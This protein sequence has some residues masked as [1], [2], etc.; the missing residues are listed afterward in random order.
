MIASITAPLAMGQNSDYY[1]LRH[2]E[3]FGSAGVAVTKWNRPGFDGVKIPRAFWRERI[4]RLIIGV[5]APDSATYEEKRRDF[6]EAFDLPH[7]GLTWLKFV[8]QGGLKLQTRV[9]LNAAIQ[10]PLLA[11]HVTIGEFRIEL[12][13]ED[14]IFYSQTETEEDITFAA[15]SGTIT[16]GGNAPIYPSLR[17]H[18][19]V[20]N[21]SIKNSG[22]N[23][24]LSLITTIGAGSYYDVDML[25]ETVENESG[26]SKY[27]E[28]NSDD[29]FW[30]AKGDNSIV[31]GGTPGGSGHKKVTFTFRN[32]YLGI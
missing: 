29:F 25:N 3:G 20:L 7:K 17:V 19:N 26:V 11:G 16:N 12:V 14:P 32:G 8:T 1:T 10:A 31:L 21:P 5:R 23:R 18:G 13:A 22:L 6:Q 24:I 30:L 2:A 9:Q 28:I 27:S 4:M 15:G